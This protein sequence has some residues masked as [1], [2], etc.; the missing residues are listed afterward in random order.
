M[1]R[2]PLDTSADTD[3]ASVSTTSKSADGSSVSVPK[4]NERKVQSGLLNSLPDRAQLEADRLAR[5]KRTLED[6]EKSGD[7]KRR[8][9]AAVASTPP[10]P[11]ISRMFYDGAFFP[12]ATSH[13]YSREDGR[14]AIGF[15]DILGPASTPDLK[16]A[17]V[18]SYGC[19]P[20]WLQSYFHPAVPV[21]LV[22]G[23]GAE[24]SGPSMRNLS[25][26]W[27]Q[28]CPKLGSGGCMHMKYMVLF[29]ESGRLRVV[30]STANLIP[31]DWK[32]LENAVFVQDVYR[33]SS[34]NVIGNKLTAE[35]KQ[36]TSESK[37]E[38]SFAKIL[39]SV[40][41]ATNVAPALEHYKKTKS[42]LPINSIDDL[43]K[44]WDWSSVTAELI[45]S[46]AGKSEGWGRIMKNGH[47]RL[48]RAL[49]TLGLATTDTQNLVVEC[50]GSSIGMYT[51][52]WFN[53]FYL[54]ASGHASA[55]KAHMDISE[56]RRKKLAYPPG[57]KVVFPTL[58]T[59]K[60][61]EQHGARSLFCTRKKWD[62]T[63]F[64]R[65]AFHDSESRAGRVLMHTKVIVH[66]LAN[67]II[68]SFTPNE[69]AEE[70]EQQSSDAAGWMYVGSHN[71]TS[72]AWGNLSG[73]AAAPVLNVNNFELGV[74][75]PLKTEKELDNASAWKR[76][77]RKYAAKDLPWVREMFSFYSGIP[78]LSGMQ[79]MDEN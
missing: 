61:T 57:V 74:V 36:S 29:Y 71:F 64:P 68:G 9:T 3:S 59:V 7:S 2:E 37:V 27:V 26:N 23:S 79:I 39:E 19:S 20:E 49:K 11:L 67:M 42:D 69:D 77:P 52:Q 16:L 15:Q 1:K 58:A 12:T 6:E 73:S 17:I 8:R 43:S 63:T 28:T 35:S 33:S 34:S 51:T 30:I 24:E 62:G 40:L 47:P 32:D 56:G 4:D 66:F 10:T 45:P 60:S 70:E 46:I 65:A 48:M 21:I 22:A 14:Q 31:I 25:D 18:S 13:A 75:V 5:R 72:P 41:K 54:S 44:L 50:Q 76:P 78:E 53:Q 55:L 38:E